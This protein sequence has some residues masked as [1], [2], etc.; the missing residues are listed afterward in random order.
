[1]VVSSGDLSAPR[2]LELFFAHIGWDEYIRHHPRFPLMAF[3]TEM[4]VSNWT[5]VV[6]CVDIRSDE[7]VRITEQPGETFPSP[8]LIASFR[9]LCGPIP[10]VMADHAN[11]LARRRGRLGPRG[12]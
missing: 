9:L 4:D 10:D 2:P 12:R 8:T 6:I 11:M 1:M 5:T 7:L 3:R